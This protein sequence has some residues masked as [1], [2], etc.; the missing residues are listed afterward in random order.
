MRVFVTGASGGIGSAVVA[1]LVAAGHTPVGLA[2]SDTAEKVVRDA[3]AEV[4]RGNLDDPDA[5]AAA[6][7]AADGVI[8]LAHDFERFAESSAEEGSAVAAIGAALEGTGKPFVVVSGTPWAPGR[9][10]TEDDPIPAEGP[11]AVR[12]RTVTA[13]LALAGRGVRVSAVRLPRSVHMAHQSSGFASVL[14]A[15]ARATGVSGYIGDGANRWPAVH[16]L[17]A[18]RL[19]RI[20]LEQAPAGSVLHAV[21]DE[22]DAMRDLAAVIGRHLDLPTASVPA[23]TFGMLGPVFAMDQPASSALTRERFGWTPEHPSLLAELELG[24]YA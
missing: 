14:V 4:L 24:D 2:R 12:S 23:E 15:T 16:R 1:E 9:V 10:A 11:T 3:G 17:D 22:G 19:F 13:A 6:A 8:H 5:L 7:G 18:A 21:A 20:A